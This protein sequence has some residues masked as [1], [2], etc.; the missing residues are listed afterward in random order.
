LSEAAF[1][2]LI[3]IDGNRRIPKSHECH[4]LAPNEFAAVQ[5][6]LEAVARSKEKS[7]NLMN[8]S[9]IAAPATPRTLVKA[10]LLSGALMAFAPGVI[11]GEPIAK[12]GTTPT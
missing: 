6:Q 8:L 4:P 10:A 5:H 2:D 9:L 3:L 7:M 1:S 11:L 12:K